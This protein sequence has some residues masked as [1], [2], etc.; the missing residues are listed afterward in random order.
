MMQG[1]G[2]RAGRVE[3]EAEARRILAELQVADAEA[4]PGLREELVALH[5]DTVHAVASR[6]RGRGEPM[7]DLVQAGS[8]GL[9]GAIDGFD[10][11][12]GTDFG[13]YAVACILGAIR[14]HFR[15]GTWSIKV[16][17]R[18]KERALTIRGL[19]D[20]GLR[21]NGRAPTVHELA[22]SMQISPE[23]VIE[24]LDA[25][26]ARATISLDEPMD[27][28]PSP[29]DGLGMLDPA[30]ESIVDRQV[31]VN[32]LKSMPELER[33]ALLL[34]TVEGLTQAEAGARLG[35]SQMQVHRLRA[36]AQARLRSASDTDQG[37]PTRSLGL[38][39]PG[40]GSPA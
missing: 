21:D 13:S 20:E 11:E 23:D 2:Q 15:E 12:R 22:Y 25:V 34:T 10:A 28:G 27:G 8:I 7:D 16:S 31:I 36:R 4:R 26:H 40:P 18:V 39:R 29:A 32:G 30:L 33:E 1:E 35:V 5:L 38:G 17:R 6:Y 37:G 14:Q 24:A 9:L 19:I 3:R